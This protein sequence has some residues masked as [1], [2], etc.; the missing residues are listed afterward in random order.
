[1]VENEGNGN[2]NDV[3]VED[4]GKERSRDG[5]KQNMD[6]VNERDKGDR[7]SLSLHGPLTP[8]T[9]RSCQISVSH[10]GFLTKRAAYKLFK[11]KS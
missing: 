4:L 2:W 3:R 7:R 8:G 11:I 10:Q 6:G 5:R 9:S 1:M